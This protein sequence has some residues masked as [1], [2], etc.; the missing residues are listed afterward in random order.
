MEYS[1]ETDVYI[2]FTTIPTILPKVAPIAMEGTNIPA[3]TLHP[4]VM[5]TKPTRMIVARSSEFDIRHW[6]DDLLTV[7]T[8]DVLSVEFT[9][10]H[11]SKTLPPPSHSL[12]RMAMLDVM[13]IRRNRLK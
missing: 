3:G 1:I 2:A 12:K 13:S 6:A 11:K 4:Y 7:R 5:T 8:E 9:Y 10:W